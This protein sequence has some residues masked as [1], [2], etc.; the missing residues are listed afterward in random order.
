[1]LRSVGTALRAT[2]QQKYKSERSTSL[3]CAR[4]FFLFPLDKTGHTEIQH[5]I[6]S[7][8]HNI[9]NIPTNTTKNQ[10]RNFAKQDVFCKKNCLQKVFASLTTGRAASLSRL[11]FGRKRSAGVALL[12]ITIVIMI[13]II[14]SA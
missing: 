14:L 11:R 2:Q 9:L 6:Y 1:M 5:K 13:I 4:K 8:S 10:L 7:R 3:V 12:L